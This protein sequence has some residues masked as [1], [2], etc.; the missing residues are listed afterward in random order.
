MGIDGHVRRLASPVLDEQL[1]CRLP[2]TFDRQLDELLE[3]ARRKFLKPNPQTRREAVEHLWDVFERVKTVF[4]SDKKTGVEK[5]L[6][7]AA[8]GDAAQTELLET[9]L[10][11]LTK[12]G[13]NFRIRHHETTTFE[14]DDALVDYLFGRMYGLLHRLHSALPG[15]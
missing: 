4:D 6:R 15:P 11:T 8:S 12:I 10:R 2:A 13:N 3:R 1:R 5:L 7:A 9:E 14:L